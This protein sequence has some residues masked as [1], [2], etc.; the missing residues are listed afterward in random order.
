M[1]SILMPIYNGIE[2]IDESVYSILT[3]TFA[4]WELI[5]GINGHPPN[6]P[7]YQV[8]KSYE[9]MDS[10]IHVYDLYPIKGKSHALNK[11]L[12][13]CKYDYVA[14]LDVD[15][16]WFPTKL[17][18]QVPFLKIYSVVGTN[19]IWFGDRN[20]IIPKIPEGDFS[21]FD[22]TI[23]NPIINSSVLLQKS[24]CYWNSMFDGVEDY[25]LW[26]RLRKNGEKFFNVKD[27]LVKHR[28]HSTSQFNAAGNN[29]KVPNLLAY[30]NL[31]KPEENR[32]VAKSMQF[33]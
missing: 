20:N 7:V 14:L 12:E 28:I 33:V 3:Q 18:K 21:N 27:V 32:P 23:V 1:I 19:C 17:A 15:D 22:F 13:L 31:K 8:A 6:S 9:K 30:H 26:L 2:F 16:I 24:L 10:R 11:M 4:D 29:N 5:I 25:D